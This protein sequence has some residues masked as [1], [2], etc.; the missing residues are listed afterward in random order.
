[1]SQNPPTIR[2]RIEAICPDEDSS[3]GY[4]DVRFWLKQDDE[5]LGVADAR[6]FYK[7]DDMSV[8]DLKADAI[9]KGHQIFSQ[10]A[11]HFKP[12]P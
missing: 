10:I 5:L 11:Q 3:V 12:T 1:M 6:V 8:A 2:T 9:V 4:V 7:R